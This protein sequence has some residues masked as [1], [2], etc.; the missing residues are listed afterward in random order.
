MKAS[1]RCRTLAFLNGRFALLLGGGLFFW[2]FRRGGHLRQF[3]LILGIHFFGAAASGF[4]RNSVSGCKLRK[5]RI[6]SGQVVRNI[7]FGMRN[8]DAGNADVGQEQT[9]EVQ[10]PVGGSNE[11]LRQI[12]GSSTS[13]TSVKNSPCRMKYS[14]KMPCSLRGRPF[15]R[16]HPSFR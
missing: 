1:G 5:P 7:A 6:L 12:N 13:L 2:K 14:I 15:R 11:R 8:L 16:T 4:H 9:P 10:N 3:F